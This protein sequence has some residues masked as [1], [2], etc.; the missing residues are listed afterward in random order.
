MRADVALAGSR[1]EVREAALGWRKAGAIDEATRQKIE[2][3]YPDDRSRLGP[4]FRVLVFCFTVVAV[5]GFFG[6]FALAAAMGRG[7]AMGVVLLLFGGALVVATEF[8]IGA[9]R[10]TQGGTESATAF[11]GLCYL[12]GGLL[13]I[14]FEGLKPGEQT[15]I[16]LAL[17][18]A[19]TVFGVGAHRWG[20][21][22]S[23]VASAAA[24]FVLLARGPLGRVSWA[25]AA[26][27]LA[28]LLVKTADS[29]RLPPAHRRCCSAMAVVSLVFLYVAVHL[30]SW[31]LSVVEM[32]TGHWRRQVQPPSAL[33][34]ASMIATAL[35]PVATLLWGMATRRRLLINLALVGILSSI[36][37]LRVYVHVAPL[38]VALLA[39]GAMAIGLA[40]GLRRLLDSGPG[41][42]R[43]GF[44]AEPLFGDPERRSALEIAASVTNLSPAARP[45]E[46]PGFEGG[47]GHFGG[48]GATGTF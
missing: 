28:P 6:V 30:G 47:G 37:T 43:S 17:V 19:A 42:E 24:L 9:L 40:L 39:G 5:S 26:L 41:H 1:H 31:D 20:Y 3:A 35:V 22:L 48:G 34:P 15:S 25:M 33:R 11:L 13:W 7:D 12:L 38:W 16:N 21:V 44:T 10:R 46:R 8:Q 18:I 45:V 29:A 32:L 4:V 27:I 2:A 23:A 14:I 36:V